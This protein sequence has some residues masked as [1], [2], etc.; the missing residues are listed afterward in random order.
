MTQNPSIRRYTLTEI[1]VVSGLLVIVLASILPFAMQL[2]RS[3]ATSS[4]RMELRQDINY[5][6]DRL[7]RDFQASSKT[8]IQTATDSTGSVLAL[9]LPL[10]LRTG[11]EDAVDTNG[12]MAWT[13]EVLYH[14]Y[15]SGTQKELRRSLVKYADFSNLTTA[16]QTAFI[17]R[18]QTTGSAFDTGYL[19]NSSVNESK[20]LLKNL[21]TWEIRFSRGD[22]GIDAYAPSDGKRTVSLG[23]A[24][25]DGGLHTIQFRTLEKNAQSGGYG[26]G[27]DT[28]IASP[29]EL[30]LQADYYLTAYATSGATPVVQNT[31][32]VPYFQN[33][34]ILNFPATQAG[35]SFTLQY[36]YD[37]WLETTFDE[38]GLTLDNTKVAVLPLDGDVV[39]QLTGNG[40]AWE[41]R[42]QTMSDMDITE[43]PDNLQ[44]CT[45]R[46]VIAGS[47]P[48]LGGMLYFSGRQV[49]ATFTNY[50]FST[51]K[52]QSAYIMER[53]GS[54]GF[55]A[56]SGT[57]TPL[58]F[59]GS[60]GF[61][62]T[63]PGWQTASVT[64]DL[65][66]FA[67]D[68][69]KDYLVSF[70]VATN[71]AGSYHAAT[72]SA[73]SSAIGGSQQASI[74]ASNAGDHSA[75]VTWPSSATTLSKVIGVESLSLT[76]PATGTYTSQVVDTTVAAPV[77][78]TM[79]W[80][81]SLPPKTGITVKAR[82]DT[83]AD[84]AT[85]SW[86]SA[87]SSN[88]FNSST[89]ATTAVDSS[90]SLSALPHGRYVQ[91]QAIL[92]ASAPYNQTPSLRDVSV[93]W[94]GTKKA[95]QFGADIAVGPQRGEFE[96]VI[97]GAQTT[98][99]LIVA[100]FTSTRAFIGKTYR[101]SFTVNLE[102]RNP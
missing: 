77:Y 86:S 36:Y 92:T 96:V 51:L 50:F 23:T 71:S 7:S 29:A 34:S 4:V 40:V 47:D 60:S 30:P 35:N 87:V 17:Q 100:T 91:L 52:V 26:L 21:E 84:M 2:L 63:A 62:L 78:G 75:D 46:V 72:W 12:V 8:L 18:V 66:D 68:K 58:K 1:M 22:D 89:T 53:S 27:V 94:P 45:V 48:A 31:V 82:A 61:T 13:D 85:Y 55:N 15:V 37:T 70:Y 43:H 9:A 56:T 33:N 90:A 93:T 10:Y 98:P 102:P 76:Y 80:R 59:S 101:E 57:V 97:D 28:I 54:S 41:A 11:T 3:S 16:N 73:G 42:T 64:S 49:C 95:V 25:V 67:V 19:A 5:A 65:A 74:T 14:L 32:A 88:S 79:R 39:V 6:R 24:L 83:R 81:A 99:P 44:G 20:T 69:T 38:T